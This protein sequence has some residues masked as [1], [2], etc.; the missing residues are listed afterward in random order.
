MR[1]TC[2]YKIQTRSNYDKRKTAL[3]TQQPPILHGRQVVMIVR[4]LVGLSAWLV[5][6]ATF[7]DAALTWQPPHNPGIFV[8]KQFGV[9]RIHIAGNLILADGKTHAPVAATAY[10]KVLRHDQ[11]TVMVRAVVYMYDIA[12]RVRMDVDLCNR[13]GSIASGMALERRVMIVG[14]S[15][16]S[17]CYIHTNRVLPWRL[18]LLTFIFS[19]LPSSSTN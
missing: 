5:L 9:H 8:P 16:C 7:S 2:A 18:T 11:H 3:Q 6:V 13:K 4:W 17:S 14:N 19:R 12:Q 1:C 10:L 15:G